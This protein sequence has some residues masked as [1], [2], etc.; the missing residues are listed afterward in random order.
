[1]GC[2]VRSY[3]RVWGVR[4]WGPGLLTGAARLVPPR[5]CAHVRR[6]HEREAPVEVDGSTRDALE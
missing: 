4:L 2:A 5:M 6:V 3:T 1:M